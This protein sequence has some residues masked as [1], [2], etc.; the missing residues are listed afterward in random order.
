MAEPSSWNV[1]YIR[2]RVGMIR[3]VM[4]VAA[5][6]VLCAT[7]PFLAHECE[8]GLTYRSMRRVLLLE[9]GAAAACGVDLPLSTHHL[10]WNYGVPVGIHGVYTTGDG[11]LIGSR[12]MAVY[13]GKYLSRYR[14]SVGIQVRTPGCTHISNFQTYL[15]TSRGTT[16]MRKCLTGPWPTRP[17]PRSLAGAGL[18]LHYTGYGSDV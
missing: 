14:N 11:S 12:P 10:K 18:H 8:G 3:K 6:C 17:Y 15:L 9:M 4:S 5:Q 16:K 2:D 13:L 7:G 1:D